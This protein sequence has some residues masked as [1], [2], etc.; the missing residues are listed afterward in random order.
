MEISHT[1]SPQSIALIEF[2]GTAMR[3]AGVRTEDQ[4]SSFFRLGVCEFGVDVEG[5]FFGGDPARGEKEASDADALEGVSRAIDDV[6]GDEEISVMR[7]VVHPQSS[8]TICFYSVAPLDAP[9]D[10]LDA[11]FRWEVGL[12]AEVSYPDPRAVTV[13]PAE[14]TEILGVP[15]RRHHLL[16]VEPA[17]WSRLQGVAGEQRVEAVQ[18]VDSSIAA[19]A[20]VAEVS[21]PDSVE[22]LVGVYPGRTEVGVRKGGRWMRSRHGAVDTSED[23]AY[24]ALNLLR[25]VGCLGEDVRFFGYYGSDIEMERL[26]LLS[27]FFPVKPRRVDPFGR[28]EGNVAVPDKEVGAFVPLVGAARL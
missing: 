27:S 10:V 1:P 24:H 8:R 22:V 13:T 7:V 3:Y 5:A 28:I 20:R 17:I 4:I 6:F 11:R 16:Y 9:R 26:D 21:A 15:H 2:D 19:S 25:Q 12:F 18:V 23:I 14:K